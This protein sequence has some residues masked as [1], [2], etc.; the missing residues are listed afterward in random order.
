MSGK[1]DKC[2]AHCFECRCSKTTSEPR[3]HYDINRLEALKI[4]KIA[5]KEI[6]EVIDKW[7]N[8]P[9]NWLPINFY[10]SGHIM[11]GEHLF[12]EYELSER[13]ED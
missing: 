5:Y 12:Q 4:A 13:R 8:G 2:G 11:V 1:C 3:N 9:I 7:N 6:R 10:C